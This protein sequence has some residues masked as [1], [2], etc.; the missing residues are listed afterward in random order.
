MRDSG[1]ISTP[2]RMADRG[3]PVTATDD[4]LTVAVLERSSVLV[5]PGHF[6]NFSRDGFLVLSLISPEGEFREGVRRLLDF[7]VV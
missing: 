7:F 5:H 4:E 1:I 2:E 6:F 3:V